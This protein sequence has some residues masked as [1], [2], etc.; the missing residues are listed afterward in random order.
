MARTVEDLQILL[1]V[2][3]GYDAGD[4]VSVPL[5]PPRARQFHA[6]KPRIGFYEDDG[7][8]TPTP[9]IRAAVRRAAQSLAENGFQVEP[10]R[11]E[12]L[13]RAREL[14]FVIFVEAIAAVLRPMVKGQEDEITDNTKEFL[15][16]AAEQPPLTGDRLLNTLLERDAL[17]S[18]LLAEM[19]RCPI[20]LAPVCSI[21][22]FLHQDAG[23]GAAHPADYVQTMSYSQHYNLLG[24]P[25]AVVPVT[26]TSEG[27]P[28]GVQIIGRPYK[29][30]EVLAVARI[31]DQK[32]GWKQPPLK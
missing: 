24:N 19:E 11:P 32:F 16:F 6:D 23:W 21:P 13:D 2:T 30:E 25:A 17:R 14:W 5:D 31:L 10:F 4:P 8:T 22:A 12:G 15:A 28:I 18:G 1:E 9:E 20:L 3:S 7:F 27:L 26:R 29:E